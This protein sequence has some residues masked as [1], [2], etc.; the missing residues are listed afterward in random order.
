MWPSPNSCKAIEAELTL[1]AFDLALG[2]KVHW[3]DD[4]ERRQ[5]VPYTKTQIVRLPANNV[6][7]TFLFQVD[8][9]IEEFQWEWNL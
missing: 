2:G 8:K 4:L 1:E 9:H 7:K 5:G 3:D 6:V